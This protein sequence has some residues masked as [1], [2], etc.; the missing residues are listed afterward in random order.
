MVGRNYVR[1]RYLSSS[2][3][4]WLTE[5]PMNDKKNQRL[6][7][8]VDSNPVNYMDFYGLQTS[9]DSGKDKGDKGKPKPTTLCSGIWM[10][11][12]CYGDSSGQLQNKNPGRDCD[13]K[14]RPT[15]F[16][17]CAIPMDPAW[18]PY[19]PRDLVV[20]T[21]PRGGDIKCRICDVGKLPFG[22]L[23]LFVGGPDAGD[24]CVTSPRKDV[25]PRWKTGWYCVRPP[26]PKENPP[27]Y[28]PPKGY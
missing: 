13:G 28:K 5:D 24:A 25:P 20:I 10:C 15:R 19:K 1:A 3:G 14:P 8:Y 22:N 9:C 17:D 27:V 12:T 11:V 26:K 6:Y 23:D 4:Q 16:G 2:K 18:K 7:Q 21:I